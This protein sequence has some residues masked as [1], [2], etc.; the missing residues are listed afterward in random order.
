[1]ASLEASVSAATNLFQNA[2]VEY[3]DVL[4]AQ[5]DLRDAR[6]VFIDTKQQQLSATVNAYQALGGGLAPNTGMVPMANGP[7]GVPAPLPNAGDQGEPLPKPAPDAVDQVE[8]LPN[9]VEPAEP[10]QKPAP[11]R[12]EQVEP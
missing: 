6:M 2:R 3:M 9:V 1:L 5:R 7:E 8:P 10:L 4:F 12:V 11:N